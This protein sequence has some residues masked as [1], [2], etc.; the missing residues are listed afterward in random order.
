ME[1]SRVDV[2]I[3]CCCCLWAGNFPCP[4]RL[5]FDCSRDQEVVCSTYPGTIY[6]DSCV[7]RFDFP[8]GSP[9]AFGRCF[10]EVEN[11]FKGNSFPIIIADTS[12]CQELRTLESEF[13]E[14]VQTTNVIAEEHVNSAGPRSRERTC[15]PSSL[16]SLP[17]FSSAQFKYLF[18]LNEIGAVLSK[19][20]WIFWWR[21]AEMLP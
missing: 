10:I 21:E 3:T 7:E 18:T 11:G 12:I 17:D 6:D 16:L 19:P 8:G 20:F 1:F 9:K 5:Q 13:E 14:D 2:C 15:R 4:K